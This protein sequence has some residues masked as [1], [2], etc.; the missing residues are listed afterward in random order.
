[1]KGKLDSLVSL[2][3]WLCQGLSKARVLMEHLKAERS[4]ISIHCRSDR[5]RFLAN[6][7]ELLSGINRQYKLNNKPVTLTQYCK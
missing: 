4:H 2:E 5:V 7:E 1:M 6:T 3:K